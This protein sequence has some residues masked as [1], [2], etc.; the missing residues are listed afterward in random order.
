LVSGE[1]LHGGDCARAREAFGCQIRIVNQYGPTECTMTS[2]YHPVKPQEDRFEVIRVGRPLANAR[3]RVLDR[4][5]QPAPIQSTGEILIGGPG[6]A[7]GYLGQAGHTAEAFVPDP[8]SEEPGERIYRTG[9]LGRYLSDGTLEFL[10]RLDHQVKI[11]GVRVE[12][13]EIE[14]ALARHP[15]VTAAAVIA[16]QDPAGGSRLIAYVVAREVAEGAV[17][18]LRSFLRERLPEPMVPAAFL[19]LSSLPLTPN[20]KVDRKSLPAL[21]NAPAQEVGSTEAPRSVTEEIVAGIWGEVLRLERVDLHTSFF[22]QG[23]H[24]LLAV[25]VL[26]RIRKSLD[27][28]LSLGSLFESP[29]VS[30]LARRIDERHLQAHGLNIPLLAASLGGQEAPLSYSQ[31][32]LWFMSQLE[33]ESSFYNLPTIVELGG[34]LDAGLLS[35]AFTEVARRHGSLR[36]LF[37]SRDRQPIQ[38]VQSPQ[39]VSLPVI[40]LS[41]L[42]ASVRDGEVRR[43]IAEEGGRPFDLTRAPAWSCRLLQLQEDRHIVIMVLHHVITDGWSNTLLVRELAQLYRS[44]AQNRPS[45]LPEP[46][47]QYTD[48]ARWQRQWLQGEILEEQL[49]YWREKL[50]GAPA[51]I[52]WAAD[53][54]RPP[55]QSFRGARQSFQI[56]ADLSRAL[57]ALARKEDCTLFMLLLTAFKVFLSHL[58]G[59]EDL[60]VGSPFNYRSWPEIEGLIGFFVNTLLFRSDLSGNPTFRD[61]L[62]KVRKETLEVFAHEHVPFQKLVEE[63]RPER[64]LAHNPLFQVGFTYQTAAGDE[65]VL[66]DLTLRSIP[67]EIETTQFDLNLSILRTDRGLIGTLQYSKDLFTPSTVSWMEAQLHLLFERVV[68]DPSL[69]LNDLRA[70]LAEGDRQRWKSVRHG[71]VQEKAKSFQSR[72]RQVVV[73][74]PDAA[75]GEGVVSG[76][77]G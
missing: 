69:R 64:S 32:R 7:W 44:Y 21:E 35:R 54:P 70:V 4:F 27:I 47:I 8:W 52:R 12:P 62:A 43:L 66:P 42:P 53:H 17:G 50:A 34:H 74:D 45:P 59:D 75:S 19:F 6:L 38:V 58:S 1:S 51:A 68:E 71:L 9:D 20:G 26:S 49:T 63:L 31:Q 5:G 22:D 24:S 14:A 16:D 33:P 56:S 28:D 72:A 46:P 77:Q 48:F 76:Q 67:L 39:P 23:G 10:G 73:I 60:V 55:V 25:R 57:E 29:T 61:L 36:T 15:S 37:S 13:A 18:M 11:R 65:I 40:D 3:L 30:E 41:A 2:T